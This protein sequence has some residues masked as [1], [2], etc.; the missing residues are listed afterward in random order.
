MGIYFTSLTQWACIILYKL[1]SHKGRENR[2]NAALLK[3]RENYMKWNLTKAT[4][5]KTCM[6]ISHSSRLN[7]NAWSDAKRVRKWVVKRGRKMAL[8]SDKLWYSLLCASFQSQFIC[9]LF[10]ELFHKD[11][12]IIRIIFSSLLMMQFLFFFFSIVRFT[13]WNTLNQFLSSIQMIK[14]RRLLE[15]LMITL[16][17]FCACTWLI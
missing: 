5:R 17:S 3:L 7:Y 8:C 10:T 12:S 16:Y 1:P 14:C 15:K 13:S 4:E 11:F 9:I 2:T 6:H